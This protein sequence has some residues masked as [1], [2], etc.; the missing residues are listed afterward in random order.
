MTPRGPQG[1]A[2]LQAGESMA[3][4][5]VMNITLCTIVISLD[6][7]RKK[8]LTAELGATTGCAG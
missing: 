6:K 5:L 2:R 1:D 8:T 4:E 7:G 3:L